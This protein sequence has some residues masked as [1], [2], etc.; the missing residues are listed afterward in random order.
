MQP[1]KGTKIIRNISGIFTPVFGDHTFGLHLGRCATLQTQEN[2][3]LADKDAAY[4][5]E[6][7]DT[8]KCRSYHLRSTYGS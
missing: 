6:H 4:L 3:F 7:Y 8:I 5:L 2:D 1:V